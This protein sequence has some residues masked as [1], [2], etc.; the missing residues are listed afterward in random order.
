MPLTQIMHVYH[1][2]KAANTEVESNF[3]K[4]TINV[5]SSHCAYWLVNNDVCYLGQLRSVGASYLNPYKTL[6]KDFCKV[7]HSFPHVMVSMMVNKHR[8]KPFIR[9]TDRHHTAVTHKTAFRQAQI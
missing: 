3:L 1:L 7:S 6:V 4:S 9:D 8:E 2:P 5:E